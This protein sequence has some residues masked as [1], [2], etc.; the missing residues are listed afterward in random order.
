MGESG[1]EVDKE[2]KYSSSGWRVCAC[3]YVYLGGWIRGMLL[4]KKA[5]IPLQRRSE[6]FSLRDLKRRIYNGLKKKKNQVIKRS[7][8]KRKNYNPFQHK[9]NS[10]S[11]RNAALND[12]PDM[13]GGI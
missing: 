6:K 9:R 11:N 7:H 4:E 1:G 12:E 13:D 8:I 3:K 2:T 10:I 5:M